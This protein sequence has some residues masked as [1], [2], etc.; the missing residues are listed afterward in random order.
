GKTVCSLDAKARKITE[1]E[2]I[3]NMVGREIDD[4]YPKREHKIGSEI[5]FEVKNWSVYD[6][7]AQRQILKDV[8]LNVRKG[9]IV[10]IAGLMGA[11]RTELA[12]SLFGNVPKYRL[13]GGE[14][15]L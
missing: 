4:I 10:G 15:F 5:V 7:V 2:I 1:H 8:S 9:E 3:R 13:I 12:L 14:M 6:P 11:G